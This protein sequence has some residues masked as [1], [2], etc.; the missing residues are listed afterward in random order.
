MTARVS[1][2]KKK[3]PAGLRGRGSAGES[4][5]APCPAPSLRILVAVADESEFT[6]LRSRLPAPE[7]GVGAVHWLAH[8]ETIADTRL[9]TGYDVIILECRA[10]GAR[11][12]QDLVR[13]GSGTPVIALMDDGFAGCEVDGAPCVF[14]HREAIGAG[15]LERAIAGAVRRRDVALAQARWPFGGAVHATA[16]WS[17][18]GALDGE[19]FGGD[20]SS[21]PADELLLDLVG[22]LPL[23]A[24]HL[25]DDG[26]IRDCAGAGLAALGLTPR[27]LQG[28]NLFEHP[29]VPAAAIRQ[30]MRGA[31]V[32][33]VRS[34]ECGG[35]L[36]HFEC[37]L[38]FDAARGRGAVGFV[39]DVTERVELQEGLLHAVETER[40]RIGA[41]LHDEVGQLLTGIACLSTALRDRL[42]GN[43]D[44]AAED[45][46]AIADV[47]RDAL[48]QVRSLSRGLAP[49][50]LA[51]EG[52]PGA[53]EDLRAHIARMHG[54]EVN[55][56]LSAAAPGFDP[57]TAVHLFRI[58]QEAMANAI[59]HGQATRID[60]TLGR[61][62][63]V[64][65]LV[66]TDNGRGF[67]PEAPRQAPGSGLG[68]MSYRATLLG[69]RLEVASRPSRGTRVAISFSSFDCHPH[70]NAS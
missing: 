51:S 41:D 30:A 14:L 24:A 55:L 66:V 35:R 37:H 60:V 43:H 44:L 34:C 62:G 47:A 31:S 7:P 38:R 12:L 25:D 20:A 9:R 11:L 32:M 53:L 36:R 42:Q 27:S 40:Q 15:R 67:E 39:H 6:R 63:G 18:P 45:A 29:A 46:A 13:S 17:A 57:E 49:V 4:G 28:R 1:L 21:A 2:P 70:E 23:I 54:V 10:Q 64:H 8:Y 68:L 48:A 5:R 16:P 58:A 19:R 3:S 65:E 61:R 56:D 59:R 69:G 26:T 33:F 22:N 50:R 52:L